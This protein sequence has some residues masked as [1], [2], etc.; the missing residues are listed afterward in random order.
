MKTK[1]LNLTGI[2]L[3]CVVIFCSMTA[4]AASI[5]H[6]PGDLNG[7]GKVDNNDKA[8]LSTYLG[9]QINYSNDSWKADLNNDGWIDVN[10]R[11][12]LLVHFGES[13]EQ[14]RHMF[15]IAQGYLKGAF[16]IDILDLAYWESVTLFGRPSINFSLRLSNKM[17][18]MVTVDKAT[19]TPSVTDAVKEEI[20]FHIPGDIDCDGTVNIGDASIMIYCWGLPT[21]YNNDSWRADLNDDGII[22]VSDATILVFYWG[23]SQAHIQSLCENAKNYLRGISALETF[24]PASWQYY[25]SGESKAKFIF[26][27]NDGQY[28]EV[29]VATT[30]G[31]STCPI[32]KDA[33]NRIVGHQGNIT[34]IETK[35]AARLAAQGVFSTACSEYE[36][37]Y[38]Q[39]SAGHPF[40]HLTFNFNNTSSLVQAAKTKSENEISAL[41][42]AITNMDVAAIQQH[43]AAQIAEVAQSL[44]AL[45]TAIAAYNQASQTFTA[46]K[47]EISQYIAYH[48]AGYVI[49]VDGKYGKDTNNG[50][51]LAEAFQTLKKAQQAIRAMNSTG[52][53]PAGGVTV[54]IKEG[55]YEITST[56]TLSGLQDSG[57]A[58][59]PIVWKAYPGEDVRITG[60]KELDGSWFSLVNSSSPVWDRI[61]SAARGNLVQINLPQH[62]ITD[63]GTL[64][65]MDT[66]GGN[67]GP[68]GLELF[69]NGEPMT[70]ARWPNDDAADPFMHIAGNV[71]GDQSK[72]KYSGSRPERWVNAENAWFTGWWSSTYNNILVPA[73]GIDTATKTITLSRDV[74]IAANDVGN[75]LYAWNILE[76][77]DKPGEYYLDRNTGNL[78][79]WAP[80]DVKAADISVSAMGSHDSTDQYMLS[81][82]DTQYVTFQGI[83]FENSRARL[84]E[85]S[86]GSHNTLEGVTLRNCGQE[87][88][89]IISG[90]YNGLNNCEVYDTG[91]SSILIGGGNRVTL[92]SCNNFVTNSDIHDWGRIIPAGKYAIV[93]GASSSPSCGVL[94]SHNDMYDSASGA[95]RF[96][97]N[98]NII[99]YNDIHD[100]ARWMADAGVIY[101]GRD[102]S[103]RG[104]EIRYNFIHNV[105][106]DS[107]MFAD[108][109]AAAWQI[110]GIYMDDA[111]S[112]VKAYGNIFYD[113]CG[114][115]IGSFGGRDNEFTNNLIVNCF[116]GID[117][118][119]RGNDFIDDK[120]GDYDML[121]KLD[122]ASKYSWKT[123]VWA[124]S[125]P[126]LAVI[127]N[128]FAQIDGTHW[129]EPEGSVFANNYGWGVKDNKWMAEGTWGGLGA[130]NY[131]K[132]TT[133]NIH[134]Y[135]DINY[136]PLFVDAGGGDFNLLPN[137]PVYD[138][139]GWRDIPFDE[140]GIKNTELPQY[141]L[142]APIIVDN[143]DPGFTYSGSWV[144]STAT[145]EYSN[146][147]LNSNKAGAT[148][149]W[150]P[151][152]PEAGW[153]EVYI[154]WAAKN[155]TGGLNGRDLLAQY[156]VNSAMG[157]STYTVDEGSGSGQWNLLGEFEFEAGNAGSVT[158]MRVNPSTAYAT[159]ADAVQ[160]KEVAAKIDMLSAQ[161]DERAGIDPR[162]VTDA[163]YNPP[164]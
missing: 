38:T 48:P 88:V 1:I 50:K 44:E 127:P 142:N 118:D 33:Q 47:A 105:H 145:D 12:I 109:A 121:N 97:G 65:V 107:S 62:G 17:T 124:E 123:G 101:A 73:V 119:R 64:V 13:E 139:V 82:K 3:F 146:S 68:S 149:T 15:D 66:Y 52:T 161:Q 43:L 133:G 11:T 132:D 55:A 163:S 56:F 103:Y 42:T 19:I 143:K 18:V 104:N 137:S 37:L 16:M 45:D 25:P 53:L 63:Y 40:T 58:D 100:V 4:L 125:Y 122:L 130:Y 80:D 144:E 91:G 70:L 154:W 114:Y 28:I 147:S 148:A 29:A 76:E 136:D 84:V 30:T 57:T 112:S 34:S 131:Y 78:Y 2:L 69:F 157:T 108:P 117:A 5:I 27:L 24:E 162:M 92:T 75:P 111:A 54:L 71:S 95:I 41:Q 135:S 26:R 96:Y 21:S 120:N 83:T 164:Q 79:F 6:I 22:D 140:I 150:V 116:G 35:D 32:I 85:M 20:A 81:M 9:K 94:I 138:I 98:N 153:Y 115:A 128:S 87:A 102:W 77:L 74:D 67:K 49:Y 72:F 160:F 89:R 110:F 59:K 90:T 51:S 159:N 14:I 158:L 23:E 39:L 152:L 8:I 60:G 10:D 126:E 141:Q 7:D 93:I 113:L 156:I 106:N 151:I 31:L 46:A 134:S 129:L 99:E 61:D 155:S 86:G 36:S